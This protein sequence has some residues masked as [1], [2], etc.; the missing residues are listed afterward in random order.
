MYFAIISNSSYP[1]ETY[2]TNIYFKKPSLIEVYDEIGDPI[3]L[4]SLYQK[5]TIKLMKIENFK[6][7]ISI[8][9][10]NFDESESEEEDHLESGGGYLYEEHLWRIEKREAIKEIKEAEEASQ[11]DEETSEDYSGELIEYE[12]EDTENE[13]QQ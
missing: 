11:E 6:S 7:I 12:T 10:L 13:K 8:S 4:A 1:D 9:D 3:Y 5:W 2:T